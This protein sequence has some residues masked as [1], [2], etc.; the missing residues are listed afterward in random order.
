M[1]SSEVL[2]F[3]FK[4]HMYLASA[5][6][7]A[8]SYAGTCALPTP[9]Q[10]LFETYG[11]HKAMGILASFHIVHLLTAIIYIEANEEVS[12][13]TSSGD[14]I[15]QG[16]EDDVKFKDS[17]DIEETDFKPQHQI[18][19][20][21]VPSCEADNGLSVKNQHSPQ[22]PESECQNDTVTKSLPRQF[23][24]LINSLKVHNLRRPGRRLYIFYTANWSLL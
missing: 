8:G 23:L 18:A 7:V 13:T 2:R 12:A 14:E 22:T 6:A 21:S 17:L 3:H 9:M 16:V 24:S 1:A 10:A 15:P 11:F 5:V 19:P 4:R 20:N